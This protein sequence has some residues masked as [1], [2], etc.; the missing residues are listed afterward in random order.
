MANPAELRL[1]TKVA[2]L[3]YRRKMRQVDI[4]RQLNLSQATVSR[5]LKRAESEGI[6]TITVHAPL[7]TYPDLERALEERYGLKEAIVVDAAEDDS[8]LLHNLGSAGGF[9]LET[10]LDRGEVIGISSWSETL[11]AAANAMHPLGHS[12][13]ARVVQI[14]GGVGNPLGGSHA[15]QLTRRLAELVNGEAVMLPAP[16]VVG[17]RE[18]RDV[19][20]ADPFV[21]ATVAMFDQV[22]LALVGIGCIEPSRML[23]RSG[24]AFSDRELEELRARGAVGDIC[25]RFFDADGVPVRT[26]LDERVISITLDQLKRIRRVV[27]IAGGSR[28]RLAIRGAVR[29][30][31]V[32]VLITDRETAE[33]L[34]DDAGSAAGRGREEHG[35]DHPWR[36]RREP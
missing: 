10:T 21:A 11:L 22:T 12:I 13:G 23:K 2:D 29:G 5:L 14:L 4:A 34:V 30:G 33:Y 32:N 8:E 20:L 27:A 1:M 19:L 26:A 7:G 17:S 24:N 6:V 9:Y 35:N 36:D 25:L 28:K 18:A 15:L 31:W 3:Y 16:G